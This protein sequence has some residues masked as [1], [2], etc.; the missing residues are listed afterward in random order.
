MTGVQTC[1]LPICFPVTI[2]GSV[3]KALVKELT[4]KPAEI[5]ETKIET[6]GKE[7]KSIIESIAGT[8][9]DLGQ[10]FEDAERK[11]GVNVAMITIK[12][13]GESY[14]QE[15]EGFFMDEEPE[16]TEGNGIIKHDNIRE[17]VNRY[18]AAYRDWE[19][20]R[21][22]IRLNSSHRSLSRMPSSA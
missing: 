9:T 18:V 3:A 20:D 1:A 21:K 4:G 8:I 6:G 17:L 2:V 5:V 13:A 22:S 16:E 12:K 7:L 15:F 10:C 11:T 19:T 14:N